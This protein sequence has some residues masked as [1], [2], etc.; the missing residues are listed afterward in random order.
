MYKT[1]TIIKFHLIILIKML[2]QFEIFLFSN[3]PNKL[4]FE[5]GIIL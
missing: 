1:I 4:L 3:Q 5:D 2:L